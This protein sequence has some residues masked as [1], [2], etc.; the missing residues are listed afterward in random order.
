[1]NLASR[2]LQSSA[3]ART[4]SGSPPSSIASRIGLDLLNKGYSLRGTLRNN[5]HAVALLNGAY[6][7]FNARVQLAIVPD[8]TA[9]PAFDEAVQGRRFISGGFFIFSFGGLVIISH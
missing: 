9:E 8:I 6:K 4:D 3:G 5:D 2:A 1:M 7:A